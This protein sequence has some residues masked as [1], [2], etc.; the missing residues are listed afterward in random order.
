MRPADASSLCRAIGDEIDRAV[1]GRRRAIDQLL[2]AV[3]AGG[4][5]LLED[6]P[7]L[8]KTQLARCLATTLGC[9]YTRVQFTPDLLP[10]DL[11]GSSLYDPRTRE[12]VFRP[13]PIFTHIL[14]ADEINRTP[15][16]TQAALLEAMQEGQVSVDGTTTRLAPPFLVLATQNPLEFEGTYPLPEAQLDRF[17]VRLSLGYLP[18]TEETNLLRARLTRRQSEVEL[19]PVV[20]VSP[21]WRCAKQLRRCTSTT[22][23]WTT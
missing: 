15:P 6:L 8:G 16:K 2:V 9:R 1:V 17:A 19:N 7:G 5:V 18:V 13:G 20:D 23:S 4:H 21:C 11:T 22:T 10:S 12:F 14:L 3:L